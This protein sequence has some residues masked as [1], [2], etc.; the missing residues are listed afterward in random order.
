ME[1]PR[2][3]SPG[4]GHALLVGNGGGAASG[5]LCILEAAGWR[6]TLVADGHRGWHLARQ[7]RPDVV[8]CDLDSPGV[9]SSVARLLDGDQPVDA[10][11]VVLVGGPDR[12]GDLLDGLRSGARDFL[13]RPFSADELLVRCRAAARIAEALTRLGGAERE[14]ALLAEQSTD[15]VWRCGIDGVIRYASPSA[16]AVLGWSPQQ[17]IGRHAAEL[18][19]SDDPPALTPALAVPA[20]EVSRTTSR[21]LKADG[22]YTWIETTARVGPG[23]EGDSEVHCTSRD[24]SERKALEERLRHLADHDPLTDLLNRRAFDA[25]VARHVAHGARYGADGALLL[26]DVDHFKQINDNL[27]HGAGDRAL[28]SLA[29]ALRARLRTSDVLA[30]LGGDEFA[31]LLPHGGEE[32]AERLAIQLV[33]AVRQPV[34][35]GVG[36]VDI[37]ISVGIAAFDDSIQDA[38][39][40]LSRAD[41]ALFDAKRAGRDQPSLFD[42]VAQR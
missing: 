42:L 9:G 4:P 6:V 39:D 37:T 22:A 19:H 41:A 27:G 8:V 28:V 11:P 14:L 31:I 1:P 30:R 35:A 25:A 23:L 18:C 29:A 34:D 32:E 13:V 17:L 15:L 33:E 40:I 5:D 26:C 36:T 24:V 2:S 21:L 3:A 10:I 38:E 12:H 20:G 7:A 16:L